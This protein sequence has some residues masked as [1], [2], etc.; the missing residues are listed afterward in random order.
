[1]W[2][3]PWP[4]AVQQCG[5][6]EARPAGQSGPYSSGDELRIDSTWDRLLG[7]RKRSTWSIFCAKP[8]KTVGLLSTRRH[9]M[10]TLPQGIEQLGAHIGMGDR[11]QQLGPAADR[12]TAHVD[13]AIF[14]GDVLHVTPC[15]DHAC[16]RFDGRD[17]A[18]DLATHGGG[19]Q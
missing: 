16:A 1:M 5:S 12:L 17:D 19:G 13:Y 6:D 2:R 18:G 11:R 4:E 9:E 8:E 3:R 7:L 14:C 10:K 15:R